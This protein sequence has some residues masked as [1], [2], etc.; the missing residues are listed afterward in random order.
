M[1]CTKIVLNVRNNFCTQHVLPRFELGISCIELVIQWTICRHIVGLVDAKIRASDKDFSIY[2]SDEVH[3]RF[4]LIYLLPDPYKNYRTKLFQLNRWCFW[5][6]MGTIW[7]AKNKKF[8]ELLWRMT[9]LKS[10][11]FS[12]LKFQIL[13]VGLSYNSVSV[14]I[15]ESENH[16]KKRI[17]KNW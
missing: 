12:T 16:L 6:G 4:S 9:H 3:R 5:L 10:A 1:L 11:D 17:K 15:F 7:E 2:I 14:H 8:P 13:V